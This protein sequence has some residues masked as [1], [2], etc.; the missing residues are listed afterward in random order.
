MHREDLHLKSERR[1]WR[2]LGPGG[3]GLGVND[4]S[5]HIPPWLV[6]VWVAV[7]SEWIVKGGERA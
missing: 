7:L 1:W 4:V 5:A 3:L 2:D 6:G